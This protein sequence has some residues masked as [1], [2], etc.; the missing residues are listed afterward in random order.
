MSGPAIQ[1]ALMGNSQEQSITVII[2]GRNPLHA[3]SDNPR[4]AEIVEVVQ[5]AAAQEDEL[6]PE[7]ADQLAGL[8]DMAAA[9]ADRFEPL[10]ERVAVRHGRVYF[11]GDEINNALT[12]QILSFLNAGVENWRPLVEFFEKV[13]THPNAGSVEQLYDWITNQHG[14]EINEDGDLVAYKGVVANG[15]GKLVS[16][17]SGPG[18]VNGRPVEGRLPNDPGNVVE[19]PRSSVAYNPS[20]ACARGLHVGTYQ[21]AKHWGDVVIEVRI[22]PRDVVSVPYDGNGEKIRVCRYAVVDR[23]EGQHESPLVL[24]HVE[25]ED[26]SCDCGEYTQDE[27]DNYCVENEDDEDDWK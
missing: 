1:F 20:V 8:F 17:S 26:D 2:P 14:V 11:D 6:S 13:M 7:Q 27:C 16:C 9:V 22:N 18:I 10:S 4:F 3:H 19:M 5:E 15:D 12:R 21:Y 24:D 25:P 23:C